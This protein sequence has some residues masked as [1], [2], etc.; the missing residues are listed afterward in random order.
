M[1]YLQSRSGG[2]ESLLAIRRR[3]FRRKKVRRVRRARR[4]MVAPI[5]IP[6]LAPVGKG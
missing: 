3:R 6:I 2:S 1:T 4:K 5:V